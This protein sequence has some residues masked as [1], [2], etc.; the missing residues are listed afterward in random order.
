MKSHRI[1]A[2]LN[3]MPALAVVACLLAG[4]ATA[5]SYYTGG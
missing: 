4:T 3:R 1:S 2:T 5:H